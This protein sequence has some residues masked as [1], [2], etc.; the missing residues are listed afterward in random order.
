MIPQALTDNIVRKQLSRLI[1]D[2]ES[3][4]TVAAWRDLP[5]GLR[6]IDCAGGRLAGGCLGS[7]H[8]LARAHGFRLEAVAVM[9]AAEHRLRFMLELCDDNLPAALGEAALAMEAVAAHELAHAL[10]PI[11]IPSC[12]PA[13]PRPCAACPRPSLRLVRHRPSGR[14]GITTRRGQPAS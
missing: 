1:A 14:P 5:A 2:A 8:R 13:M 4:L 6:I 11:P 10:S 7:G 9:V 3:L 12:S